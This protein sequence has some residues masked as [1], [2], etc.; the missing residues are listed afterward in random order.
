MMFA[1]TLTIVM[2]GE[3]RSYEE[4]L[5][6][7]QVQQ[8]VAQLD[9]S[10]LQESP[11][12]QAILIDYQANRELLYK[13]LIS[14]N[15]YREQTRRVLME[16]G[17]EPEFQ[18]ILIQYGDAVILPVHYFLEHDIR[19]IALLN[20]TSRNIQAGTENARNLWKT[21]RGDE[22]ATI[23]TSDETTDARLG[24]RER[25]WY[26]INFIRQEGHNFLGQFVVDA[27][28]NVKWVQTERLLEGLSSFL[29]GGIRRLE[30][31][32]VLDEKITEADILWATFDV[33][34][35]VGS[36][37]LLRATKAA[38]SSG[39]SLS[40]TART[41][42]GAA[43]LLPRGPF[44]RWMGKYG[45]AVATIYIV[46][47][48]PSLLNSV[49]TEIAE[50]AGIHPLFVQFVGWILIISLLLYPFL[51]VLKGVV[52]MLTLFSKS[53]LAVMRWLMPPPGRVAQGGIK[54]PVS[55]SR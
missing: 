19:S 20:F 26:A 33:A 50:L 28:G 14:L 37:K 44:L 46:V 18:E 12:V 45:G 6:R 30:T 39:K 25:G 3:P 48:H 10:I 8:E 47:R 5:I 55:D 22:P 32:Y 36:F 16:Y 52:Y 11:E 17:P 38:S 35:V 27:A 29:A 49:F 42:H 1:I 24:P 15:K 53:L 21:I 54:G 23:D 43:R 34:V 9:E 51:W 40:L 41:W 13:T 4:Q 31:K 2:S 7:I